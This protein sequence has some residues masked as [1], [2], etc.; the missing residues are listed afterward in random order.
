MKKERVLSNEVIPMGAI[1]S[2]GFLAQS[3]MAGRKHS[4][5]TR[6]LIELVEKY[7]ELKEL[8]KESIEKAREANPDLVTNPVRNL[9]EYYSF[10]DWSLRAMPWGVIRK[11]GNSTPYDNIRQSI[12]YFYFIN[13]QPLEQLKGRGYYNNSVQYYEPYRS[14]IVKYCRKWGHFLSTPA[15]WNQDFYEI[16]YSDPRFGLQND[17]YEDES[18]WNSFNAFFS[19]RLKSPDRRPVALPGNDEVICSPA[20]AEPQ[21]IWNIDEKSYIVQ[22]EGVLIKSRIFN[23]ISELLGPN[24]KYADSFADGILTHSFLD[25][26]DYHRYH[27]PV[28]GIIR[29]IRVIPGNDAAGGRVFWDKDLQ[30]YILQCETPG[31]QSIETRGCV[32]VE[33]ESNGLVALLPIGMSQVN[34]VNFE[35]Y[36]RVG[37]RVRKGDM[38]GYFLFGGSDFVI[39]FQKGYDFELTAP[40]VAD[41]KYQHL[42]MGEELGR[43][44][45]K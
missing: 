11:S 17:W 45:R 7:P 40:Q 23:S 4:E 21:G 35:K 44:K 19:R 31:W 43:L 18:N 9:E 39:L 27:F 30:R 3:Q 37:D 32:I 41:E 6:S 26:N 15:S 36:L 13:D 1:L 33:T 29:E 8:L 38:M 28:S 25:V 5:T 42:L 16:V 34:S 10:I 2:A 14:W 24:S 20:D 12:H 22:K